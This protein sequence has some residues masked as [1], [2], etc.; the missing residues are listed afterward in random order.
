M[1][2]V[3]VQYMACISIY[4][5]VCKN[6]QTSKQFCLKKKKKTSQAENVQASSI[7]YFDFMRKVVSIN[8]FAAVVWENEATTMQMK[9]YQRERKKP[10]NQN[11]QVTCQ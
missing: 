4:I 6:P 10:P 7:T 9:K 1:S 8:T 2:F 3:T 11:A 5:C